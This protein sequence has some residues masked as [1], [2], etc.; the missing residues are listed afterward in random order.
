M[1]WA[2]ADPIHELS[3]RVITASERSFLFIR[4]FFIMTDDYC[5]SVAKGG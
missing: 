3:P 5:K 1:Y 2:F 4:W